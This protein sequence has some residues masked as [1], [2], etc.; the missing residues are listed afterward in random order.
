MIRTIWRK[1]RWGRAWYGGPV[2]RPDVVVSVSKAGVRSNIR[3]GHSVSLRTTSSE[4][5]WWP[6]LN[7]DW[8]LCCFYSEMPWKRRTTPQKYLWFSLYQSAAAVWT[9]LFY[10][11]QHSVLVE[12]L[13]QERKA[14]GSSLK[15]ECK[16][17]NVLLQPLQ[18]L[19]ILP[20]QKT[21][22]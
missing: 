12:L 16:H 2:P 14:R 4:N 15:L 21:K 9:C 7:P 3:A 8:N 10:K 19:W 5:S 6:L 11:K 1:P 18:F 17:V 20:A 13:S 22:T